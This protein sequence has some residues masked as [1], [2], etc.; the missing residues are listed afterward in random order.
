MGISVDEL[1]TLRELDEQAIFEGVK[2][3]WE[4]LTRINT[5]IFEYAKTLPNDFERIEEFIWICKGTTIRNK[6]YSILLATCRNC[7]LDNKLFSLKLNSVMFTK[8]VIIN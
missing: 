3:P 6:L 4:V 8:Y 7:E 2:H 5:F 1:F